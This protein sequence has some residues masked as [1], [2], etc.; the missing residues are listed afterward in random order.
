AVIVL[1]RVR[2]ERDVEVAGDA[3]G[4]GQRARALAARAIHRGGVRESADEVTLGGGRHRGLR[5]KRGRCG[6]LIR[7][8][9]RG[10][11]VQ[12]SRCVAWLLPLLLGAGCAEAPEPPDKPEPPCAELGKDFSLSSTGS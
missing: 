4:G 8:T 11:M 10:P 7:C 5:G 12:G 1:H 3:V 6:N 2:D 9:A